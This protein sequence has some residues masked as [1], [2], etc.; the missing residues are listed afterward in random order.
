MSRRAGW[1][2]NWLEHALVVALVVQLTTQLQ[3]LAPRELRLL[4]ITLMVLLLLAGWVCI[5][6]L[7][8]QRQQQQQLLASSQQTMADLDRELAALQQLQPQDPNQALA[9]RLE[10]LQQQQRALDQMTDNL[11]EQ[12]VAPRQMVALLEPVLQQTPEL[13]LLSLENLPP[14]PVADSLS[15]AAPITTSLSAVQTAA[16][17]AGANAMTA[18]ILP[19]TEAP[20][21]WKHS[22]RIRLQATWS[23][24]NH[25]LR[26]L[27]TS[28]GRIYWQ[29]LDYR[30]QE[31]PWGELSLTVFTLSTQ[32]E[33]VGG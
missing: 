20:L 21:L 27:D 24:A 13:V 26:L 28:P 5:D 31:H 10:R 2:E 6:P 9:R 3:R 1:A 18:S 15:L 25:Y 8:Q 30:L 23:G 12:L 33:V 32:A 19:I 14:E 11:S 7:W 4:S 22:F 17:P 29:S 16:V